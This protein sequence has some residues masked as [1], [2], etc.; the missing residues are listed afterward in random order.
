RC[1]P[2]ILALLHNAGR[3][4]A[5]LVA[6]DL[7]FAVGPRLNAAGRLEDM[8]LGIACLLTDDFDEATMMAEQ[9]NDLNQQRRAIESA[10]QDEAMALLQQLEQDEA[11]LPAGLCL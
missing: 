10:M 3:D 6:S 8:S 9:L 5:R 4:P 7:G 2:G 1:C 11:G